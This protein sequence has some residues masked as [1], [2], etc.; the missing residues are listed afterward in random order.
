MP[1]AR[2]QMPYAGHW[3]LAGGKIYMGESI[4]EAAV[5]EIYEET[6][7]RVAARQVFTALDAFGI[8][9]GNQLH[10]HFILLA[11]LCNWLGGAP[12]ARD[13]ALEA[14]R[15]APG[16]LAAENLALSLDVREVIALAQRQP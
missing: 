14:R 2:C 6:G 1:D 7:V 11:V 16:E 8:R 3:G 5:C 13:D 15:F 9:K 12:Q 4:S 10:K